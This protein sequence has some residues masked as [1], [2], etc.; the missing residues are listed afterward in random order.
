MAE[1]PSDKQLMDEAIAIAEE[2]MHCGE[3]P[4]GVVLYTGDGT[5]LAQGW[6]QRRSTGDIT[7]HAEM[8]A[9]EA[10]A[11]PGG[12]QP[13][14]LV[15]AGTLEPCVMCWGACLELGV[16]KIVYGLEAPPNG[17][18]TRVQD[19]SRQPEVSG[20]VQRDRCRELFAAWLKENP[21]HAGSGFVEGLLEAT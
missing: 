6:N 8:V 5:R 21:D 10:A 20:K 4:I 16:S 12:P 15:L 19:P 17:G 1:L 2:A 13:G 11:Q 9:F 14:G 7:R 18:S 3:A